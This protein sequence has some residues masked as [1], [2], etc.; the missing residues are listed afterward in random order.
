MIIEQDFFFLREG[1]RE[2]RK[3]TCVLSRWRMGSCSVITNW[4][5]TQHC[6]RGQRCWQTL[7]IHW[8]SHFLLQFLKKPGRRL[9]WSGSV[10]CTK[11]A[12]WPSKRVCM[13]HTEHHFLWYMSSWHYFSCMSINNRLQFSVFYDFVNWL[14]FSLCGLTASDCVTFAM[15][16]LTW[17]CSSSAHENKL[18]KQLCVILLSLGQVPKQLDSVF[19]LV[20]RYPVSTT[21]H[22]CSSLWWSCQKSFISFVDHV[23]KW[24]SKWLRII[25]CHCG[26]VT[27]NSY[28]WLLQTRKLRSS[29]YQ[30]SSL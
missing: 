23:T 9:R 2:K 29:C 4:W 20:V 8:C 30:K 18:S 13:L 5:P 3:K 19:V 15:C 16:P 14:Q 27:Q 26:W 7:G 6:V 11:N 12:V 24:L 28:G 17:E 25:C 10:A 21:W 1:K 22:Q